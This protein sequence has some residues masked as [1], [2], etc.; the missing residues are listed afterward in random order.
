MTEEIPF[1]RGY[2]IYAYNSV[3]N[4]PYVVTDWDVCSIGRFQVHTHPSLSCVRLGKMA[5][6]GKVIDPINE[7]AST[8][9]IIS[10]LLNRLSQGRSKFLDYLDCLSGRFIIFVHDDNETFAVG[11]AGGTKPLIFAENAPILSSHVELI[12]KSTDHT[13]RSFAEQVI[14]S[15]ASAYP[16]LATEYQ[17]IQQLTPNTLLDVENKEIER[18][19]PREPLERRAITSELVEELANLF[20][21][22]FEILVDEYDLGLSLS[23][24]VDSR[25]SFAASHNI[26]KQI[27]Y[28]SWIFEGGDGIDASTA[29]DL[30]EYVGVQHNTYRIKE[31][32]DQGFLESFHKH[33]TDINRKSGRA[34]NAYNHLQ[35]FPSE[36]LEIRSNMAEIGRAFYR[37]K[38]GGLPNTVSASM[39]A[40]LYGHVFSPNIKEAFHEFI[41]RTSF[42]DL[43]NYD[44][45]DFF[46]W[47]YKM[48]RWLSQ[49]LIEKDISHE[50]YILFNNREILKILLS[51]DLKSRRNN[52]LFLKVI[53]HLWPECLDIP[54]NPHKH[55]SSWYKKESKRVAYGLA[56]R[57][58]LPV[59]RK[60]IDIHRS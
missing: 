9:A 31:D 25:L 44:P 37:S 27:D 23:A 53:E 35:Q 30:C 7:E 47:E 42:R 16:G 43:Y 54:I 15:D 39:L 28:Y 38:F 57:Q 48:G 26:R 13:P 46:Y 1:R 3:R 19:F 56:I 50:N 59:Y 11:D 49:W 55:S 20:T 58:P 60:I 24:G 6:L 5:L 8:S 36:K 4:P 51:V 41:E 18:I 33:A 32:P 12:A 22:Q 34:Q 21:K 10:T 40:K 52:K 14:K 2:Y 29:R 45:Y 17:N